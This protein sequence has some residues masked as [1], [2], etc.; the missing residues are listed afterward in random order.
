MS[1]ETTPPAGGA[2]VLD[3]IRVL[4]L[5]AESGQYCGRL[6]ADLGADV[7]KLEPPAG[8]AVRRRPPF[9]DG[10]PGPERGLLWWQLNSGKRSLALDITAPEGRALLTRLLA[11]ADVALCAGDYD[12][13]HAVGAPFSQPATRRPSLIVTTITPYGMTGPKRRR[14]ACDLIA[15]AAG[16]ILSA[17]GDP[18]DSP[19][20][21]GA[22][23]AYHQASIHATVGTLMALWGVRTGRP[24][25]HVEISL[26]E[27]VAASFQPDIMYWDLR[28]EVR[29][30]GAGSMLRAGSSI[31]RAADG[32]IHLHVQPHRFPVL[33][34]WLAA[35]GMAEDLTDPRWLDQDVRTAEAE[36]VLAVVGRFVATRTRDDLCEEA[37][38]RDLIA[39]PALTIDE[40]VND[41]QVRARDWLVALQQHARV[42]PARHPGPPFRLGKRPWHPRGG[43]PRLGEHTRE[44]L[45]A[46]GLRQPELVALAG[47]GVIA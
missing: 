42:E 45:T 29:R 9:L 38:Q 1:P 21:A 39:F 17:S 46:L 16:G 33:I 14:P 35:A 47:A 10:L 24:G 5:A 8:D 43:A 30:R 31:Y 15:Q 19:T 41:R 6:L 32:W 22:S 3:G 20:M 37:Q 11:R 25:R 28:Q 23:I 40:F 2:G 18:D 27:S 36:H 4:E 26:Q 13:L 34:E 44:I 7:I 12:R